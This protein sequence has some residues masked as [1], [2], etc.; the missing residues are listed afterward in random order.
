MHPGIT[1]AAPISLMWGAIPPP[2]GHDYGKRGTI[3]LRSKK[4]PTSRR[5]PAPHPSGILPHFERNPHME[6]DGTQVPMVR[7]E[8]E[9]R[10]GRIDGQPAVPV[11]E[12]ERR[13]PSSAI[14]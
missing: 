5:N 14:F 6:M 9:G 8:L 2:L 3:P 1:N 11:M 12:P 7:A 10:T 4:G 13:S